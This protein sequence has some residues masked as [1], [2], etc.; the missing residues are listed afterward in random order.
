M[1]KLLLFL[2][3]ILITFTAVAMPTNIVQVNNTKLELL[4]TTSQCFNC[5]AWL[6]FDLKNY[7]S[8]LRPN[9][10]TE[11]DLSFV[12]KTD[13]SVLT[14]WGIE[15]YS[16]DS[17]K[18]AWQKVS[19]DFFKYDFKKGQK[20]R[21]RIWGNLL[22]TA[23]PSGVDW[24]L[25]V[26]GEKQTQW[27]WWNN[28]WL[29]YRPAKITANADLNA[30]WPVDINAEQFNLYECFADGNCQSDYDDVRIVYNGTEYPRH[31]SGNLDNNRIWFSLPESMNTADTLDL[32]IFFGNPTATYTD[33]TDFNLMAL[34]SKPWL[35]Y[36]FEETT[37]VTV[38]DYSGNSRTGTASV[39]ASNLTLDG[40]Y[41]KD[42]NFSNADIEYVTIP[43]PSGLSSG[44]IEAFVKPSTD[45]VGWAI[46]GVYN[47][48]NQN[49]Q[50]VGSTLAVGDCGD[51]QCVKFQW[52]SKG[53]SVD[54]DI[55]TTWDFK[56][57]QY[58]HLV[59]TWGETAKIIVDGNTWAEAPGGTLWDSGDNP[60]IGAR[61]RQDL[62]NEDE[63][64][65]GHIDEFRIKTGYFDQNTYVTYPFPTQLQNLASV[66]VGDLNIGGLN[67]EVLVPIDEET[68][69]AIDTSEYSF[70]VQIVD[71]NTAQT[72]TDLISSRLFTVTEDT[73]YFLKVNID[74]NDDYYGRSYAVKVPSGGGITTL[75]P[76]VVKSA[77][78][79]GTGLQSVLFARTTTNFGIPDI[80][81]VA[82]KPTAGGIVTVEDIVT[83]AAGEATF[84]FVQGDTYYL[85]LYDSNSQLIWGDAELRPVYSG[86]QFY[87]DLQEYATYDFNLTTFDVNYAPSMEVLDSN[88]T[89]DFNIGLNVGGATIQS[90]RIH[91]FTDINATDQNTLF[92]VNYLTDG[93]KQTGTLSVVDMNSLTVIKIHTVL[94][95]TRGDVILKTKHYT[96]SHSNPYDMFVALTVDFPALL[97]TGVNASRKPGTTFLAVI[98]TILLVGAAISKIRIDIAGSSILACL[99]LGFF[100]MINWIGIEIFAFACI[101]AAAFIILTRGT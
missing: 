17:K 90:I 9:R 35:F 21:L 3:I 64:F 46:A 92:D 42:F 84:A 58:Y 32:N 65:P 83:D 53:G 87:L 96:L 88:T 51:P 26:F 19:D 72:Q 57:D 89:V 79:G 34:D 31:I 48:G 18:K 23:G 85:D 27:S 8:D 99:V 73:S 71:G 29:F 60:T 81:F 47:A 6:D 67:F 36:R 50:L 40:A 55:S 77:A 101:V 44:S 59:V 14:D 5:E 69:A 15:V 7:P 52:L 13:D 68:G 1:R 38:N 43:K 70:S 91:V 37:G 24:Q 94:T 62:G 11:F 86:Y 33:L 78:A 10:G 2:G 75:Q 22:P 16:F 30:G 97:N 54:W 4:E 28:D 74:V 39:D 25:T 93:V 41:N 56:A 45:N 98:I 95:T 12:K 49:W 76:Y 100:L 20:Y 80:R 63:G 61:R 82:K 66:E